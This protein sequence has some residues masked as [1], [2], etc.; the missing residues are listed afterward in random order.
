VSP[1][2]GSR[3]NRRTSGC[4]EGP[5]PSRDQ[6]SRGRPD[7]SIAV[8]RSTINARHPDVPVLSLSSA[9]VPRVHELYREISRFFQPNSESAAV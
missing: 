7:V 5:S 8:D 1:V 6:D 3:R 4:A 2:A 9:S